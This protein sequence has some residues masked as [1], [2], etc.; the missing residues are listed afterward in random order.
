M[1][2]ESSSVE[3]TELQH[4]FRFLFSLNESVTRTQYISVG[5]GLMALKYLIECLFIHL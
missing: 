4:K 5:F 1:S 2:R 3:Q